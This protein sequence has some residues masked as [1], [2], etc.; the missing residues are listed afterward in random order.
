MVKL[1]FYC[2][3]ILIQP[4]LLNIKTEFPLS[5]LLTAKPNKTN[6][7]IHVYRHNK[8]LE[9]HVK[10]LNWKIVHEYFG[11]AQPPFVW[12]YDNSK[13]MATFKV[14]STEPIQVDISSIII[15][16][17]YCICKQSY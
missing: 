5:M 16:L 17:K 2:A 10:A 9:M 11:C 3:Q 7:D 8:N 6:T 15:S 1:P 12:Y 4:I 14:E 13:C